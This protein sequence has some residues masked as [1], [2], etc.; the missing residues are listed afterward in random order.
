LQTE[1]LGR[2]RRIVGHVEEVAEVGDGHGCQGDQAIDS[3]RGADLEGAGL[4][5][6]FGMSTAAPMGSSETHH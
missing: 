5:C 2:R 6:T 3:D 4:W 1:P